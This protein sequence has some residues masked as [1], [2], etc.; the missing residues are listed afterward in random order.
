MTSPIPSFYRIWFTIVDPILASSGLLGNL[1]VPGTALRTYTP[2]AVL[3]PAPETTML[4]D[5]T[6]GFFAAVMFLSIVLLRA[7]PTDFGLWRMVMF[8]ILLVDIAILGGLARLL[9]AEGRTNPVAWRPEEWV[10]F[11][12]TAGVAVIRTAFCLGVGMGS[13]ALKRD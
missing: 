12:I 8:S 13:Q 4:L 9:R 1:F 3:P 10:N 7:R 11:V 5:T 2:N 6:A